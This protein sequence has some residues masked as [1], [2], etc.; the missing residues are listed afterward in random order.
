MFGDCSY[1]D[2]LIAMVSEVNNLP[3][4]SVTKKYQIIIC[5]VTQNK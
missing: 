5:L 2:T 3:P 1:F 4:A